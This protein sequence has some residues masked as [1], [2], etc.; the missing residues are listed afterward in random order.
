MYS[1]NNSLPREDKILVGLWFNTILSH[2]FHTN[3]V[4]LSSDWPVLVLD[5]N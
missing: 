3:S 5:S 4:S 1:I 2:D